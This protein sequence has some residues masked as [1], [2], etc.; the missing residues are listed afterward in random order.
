MFLVR[1]SLIKTFI[2]R[3]PSRLTRRLNCRP[4]PSA[5]REPQVLS[6]RAPHRSTW[7]DD[8]L[9]IEI[10]SP[11]LKCQQRTWLLYCP[12][13]L[14]LISTDG[15]PISSISLF[16][17]IQSILQ[18]P[19]TVGLVPSKPLALQESVVR[20][21]ATLPLQQ[22]LVHHPHPPLLPSVLTRSST[23][24]E[25]TG[26]SEDSGFRYCVMIPLIVYDYPYYILSP[27][28]IHMIFFRARCQIVP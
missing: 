26:A 3:D 17:L 19:L 5:V 12:L 10:R 21:W 11:V 4:Y 16:T 27:I 6:A 8:S 24:K 13:H 25:Y 18:E 22:S 1:S 28:Q 23:L 2:W 14:S 9:M 7:D 20:L 15:R